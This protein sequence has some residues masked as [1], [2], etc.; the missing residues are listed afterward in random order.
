MARSCQCEARNARNAASASGRTVCHPYMYD[1]R[2]SYMTGIIRFIED[3]DAKASNR[4]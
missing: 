1:E 2:K 3:I 4:G